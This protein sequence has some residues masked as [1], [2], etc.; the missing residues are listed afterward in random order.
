ME[1]SLWQQYR[2][3]TDEQVQWDQLQQ[4]YK[5]KVKLNV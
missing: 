1:R 3:Q 2:I 4:D 5:P